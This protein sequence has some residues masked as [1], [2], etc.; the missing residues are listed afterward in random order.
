[1]DPT[2]EVPAKRGNIKSLDFQN[3]NNRFDW[4][5]NLWSDGLSSGVIYNSQSGRAD[6][7]ADLVSWADDPVAVIR[8][9]CT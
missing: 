7:D 9:E 3:L 1:M 6:D 5:P 2:H 4:P 8:Y